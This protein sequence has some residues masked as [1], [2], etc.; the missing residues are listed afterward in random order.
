[1]AR[2]LSDYIAK[3]IKQGYDAN[4][5]RDY[6]L[7]SGYSEA[8]VDSAMKEIYSGKKIPP[9]AAIIIL[10]AVIVIAAAALVIYKY[11]SVAEKPLNFE[12]K[13]I[14]TNA[15][16]GG[17][18]SFS[19]SFMNF[20]RGRQIKVE[21]EILNSKTKEIIM[22]QQESGTIEDVQKK[23]EITL[24]S[25]ILPGNYILKSTAIQGELTKSAT[26]SFRVYQQD[27]KIVPPDKQ[28]VNRTIKPVENNCPENCDDN[29]KCTENSCNELTGYQC[30]YIKITPCCGNFECEVGENYNSCQ[31][32]CAK[33]VDPG[34]LVGL[35]PW[36]KLE[37]IK[38][39]A[40][41]E[42]KKAA[43]NCKQLGQQVYIDQCLLNVGE[44]SLKDDYCSGI[45]ETR[46]KDVCLS[47][48]AELANRK[49]LCDMISAENR[50]DS[51]YMGFVMNSKDYS[52]CDKVANPYLK[53][54]CDSL[55]ELNTIQQTYSE[56][57]SG[58]STSTEPAGSQNN[59]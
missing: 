15:M 28:P 9:K 55:R 19:K 35:S 56:Q 16:P 40:R 51:C 54:S 50:R 46:T 18:I 42:D 17:R 29:N 32:D 27:Q 25:R 7:K 26:L 30:Q 4:T 52:V 2:E 13:G 31:E 38:D 3:Q 53:Q 44:V 6:L 47:K 20:E 57:A 11:S 8:D 1:M 10:I 39:I 34:E 5:I 58:Q 45:S 23:T 22:S 41:T 48:I 24:P 12:L 21:N 36:E 33:P 59:A 49:E 43:E 37:K 14:V